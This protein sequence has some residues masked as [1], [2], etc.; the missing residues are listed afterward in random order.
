M[1]DWRDADVIVVG[2]GPGGL[3]AAAYLAAA[4]RRLI[5]VEARDVPGGHQSSFTRNGYDFDI[6]LHYVTPGPLEDLL[7]PLGLVAEFTRFDPTAMFTLIFEGETVRVPL[8]FDAA[9]EAL[10]AAFPPERTAVAAFLAT[11][12]TL[13]HDMQTMQDQPHLWEQPRSLAHLLRYARTTLGAYLDSLHV[14]PRLRTVLSWADGVFA[15]PPSRLPMLGYA[16]VVGGYLAD[17]TAYPRTG[18]AGISAGLADV[19]RRHGGQVLLRTE[20]TGILVDGGRVRGVRVRSADHDAPAE[21]GVELAAPVVVAAGDLK[22]TFLELLP[23]EAVPSR[24]LHRIRGFEMALPLAAVHLVLDR[25]LRAEGF[26]ATS[27]IVFSGD[28]GESMYAALRAGRPP[29][30]T[31]AHL[32]LGSVVDPGNPRLCRPGQSNLQLITVTS[33]SHDFWD[34]VPGCGATRRYEARKREVRDRLVTLAEQAIPGLEPSIIF[35]DTST[36]VTDERLMRCTGGTPYGIAVTPEQMLRRPGPVTAIRG[37]FLAGASTRS[38]HGLVGALTGG[39][40]A[41]SAVLGS[42]PP[43]LLGPLARPHPPVRLT[44]SPV[45]AVSSVG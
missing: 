11:I 39:M 16:A 8:G 17:G 15:V 18:S 43:A 33:A 13:F 41:A 31:V 14:S 21:A 19:V 28:D 23:P 35:E 22:R 3:A 45:R 24:L 42:R 37:L 25:D 40:A 38:M 29:A 30:G 20:V 27:P 7:S 44:S 2:S 9:L 10:T 4:G 5:V 1:S 34:V 36:P 6:G 32:G 12:E 26:P